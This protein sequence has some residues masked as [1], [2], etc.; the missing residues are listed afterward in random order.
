[1]IVPTSLQLILMTSNS[2]LSL[3]AEDV[4]HLHPVSKYLL[5]PLAQNININPICVLDNLFVLY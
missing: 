3:L 5:S 2:M 4:K 1:M